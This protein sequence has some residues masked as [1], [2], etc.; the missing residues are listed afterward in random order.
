MSVNANASPADD[1][2]PLGAS[3]PPMAD[4][5]SSALVGTVVLFTLLMLS[6]SLLVMFVALF[7]IAIFRRSRSESNDRTRNLRRDFESWRTA[8]WAR[9][10]LS[11]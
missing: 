8:S 7:V 1:P 9:T 2:E 3:L 5:A 10:R 6:A 4:P 11:K